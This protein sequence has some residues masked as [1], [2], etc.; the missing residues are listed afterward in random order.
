MI[1]RSAYVYCDLSHDSWEG[2]NVD[3][4]FELENNLKIG[5][6]NYTTLAGSGEVCF[7]S[8]IW[9]VLHLENVNSVDE[10]DPIIAFPE[11][12]PSESSI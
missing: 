10:L 6:A 11:L 7:V 3:G 4:E 2:H 1:S 9:S 5:L 12:K 8:W